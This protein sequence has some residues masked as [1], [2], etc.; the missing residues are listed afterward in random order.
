VHRTT[1]SVSDAKTE[2]ERLWAHLEQLAKDADN[3]PNAA[4]VFIGWLAQLID[5]E[6]NEDSI[7]V[8]WLQDGIHLSAFLRHSLDPIGF[9]RRRES[10]HVVTLILNSPELLK[11]AEKN[12]KSAA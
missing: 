6:V 4:G 1:V 11:L 12:G 2:R 7:G 5:T 3:D 10:K 9:L 8:E